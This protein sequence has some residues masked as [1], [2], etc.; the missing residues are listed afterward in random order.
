MAGGRPT[1]MRARGWAMTSAYAGSSSVL[2]SAQ[3][4][5]GRGWSDRK[6]VPV[7]APESRHGSRVLTPGPRHVSG[8]CLPSQ[9][10]SPVTAL[11]SRHGSRVPS[12]LPSPDTR[13][14]SR[15][16]IVSPVTALESSRSSRVPSRLPSPEAQSRSCVWITSP[17]VA[18]VTGGHWHLDP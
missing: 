9:L 16:W 3:R 7:T 4:M 10:P 12:R 17:V 5:P 15:V 18:L 1:R 2:I 11:E 6:K 14:S 13:S 8:S